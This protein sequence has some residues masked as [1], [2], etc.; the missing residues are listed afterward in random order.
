MYAGKIDL[1]NLDGSCSLGV[2]VASDELLLDELYNFVENHLIKN[3]SNWIKENY[4]KVLHTIYSLPKRAKLK[5]YCLNSICNSPKPFF[6]STNFPTL[7]GNILLDLLKRNDLTM[8][9]ID[10][11]NS[12]IEWGIHQTDE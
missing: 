4:V 10:V 7:K 2:L 12:L 3:Q 6:T 11:W 9:E 8:E 5:K 1:Q